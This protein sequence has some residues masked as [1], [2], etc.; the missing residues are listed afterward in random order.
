MESMFFPESVVIVGVSNSPSNNGRVIVEN[1]DRFNYRGT[2]YLVGSKSDVLGAR[3]VFSRISEI[4]DVP[5]LAVILVPA[6][7][8]SDVLE[9]C[10]KKGIRRVVIETGGFSELARTGKDWRRRFS[11][12]RN[13]GI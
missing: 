4:P 7:G 13:D 11:M 3:E 5:D 10:G 12:P 2:I 9:A 6:R 1:M 8:L